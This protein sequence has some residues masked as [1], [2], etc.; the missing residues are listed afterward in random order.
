MCDPKRS[1]TRGLSGR[2]VS[3]VLNHRDLGEG[4][5]P[6]FIGRWSWFSGSGEIG[7]SGDCALKPRRGLSVG[8]IASH[9]IGSLCT[10]LR[11]W[12]LSALTDWGETGRGVSN[13][14]R[15]DSVCLEENVGAGE[16]RRSRILASRPTGS[17]SNS[18][19][20]ADPGSSDVF[21]DLREEFIRSASAS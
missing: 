16:E 5:P 21:V 14:L 6:L 19:K 15:V 4:V 20:T 10:G 18:N 13:G 2:P 17:A 1:L 7:M 8:V 3:L 12:L 9:D 11:L